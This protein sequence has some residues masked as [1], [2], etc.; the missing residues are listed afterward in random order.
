MKALFQA[1]M[2]RFTAKTGT[3]AVNN[4]LHVALGGRLY[5]TEAPQDKPMP[6]GVFSLVSDVAE[7]TLTENLENC[8]VQFSLFSE[9]SSVSEVADAFEAL[10]TLF[11]DCT[12]SVTGYATIYMQRESAQLLR[13]DGIWHYVIE[14]RVLLEKS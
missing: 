4:A 2:T 1:I 7:N 6:Y 12:L 5:N 13:Q 3:P 14:Y 9:L 10:K 8:L 11:D